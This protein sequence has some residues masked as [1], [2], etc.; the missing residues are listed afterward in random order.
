MPPASTRVH[1]EDTS[2]F[3]HHHFKDM[4]VA[5]DVE[6]WLGIV[7]ELPDPG[8]VAAGVATDVGDEYFQP[9][10]GK[11]QVEGP[12]PTDSSIIDIAINATGGFKSLQFIQEGWVAKVASVP[13]FVTIFKVFKYFRVEVRMGIGEETDFHGLIYK[14][15]ED[16]FV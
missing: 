1:V 14:G 3:I 13:D 8:S 5:T 15:P 16:H 10:Y 9:L 4:A 2:F 7:K 11:L 6:P 12:A